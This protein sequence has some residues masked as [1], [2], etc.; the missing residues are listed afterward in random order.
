MTPAVAT[1]ETPQRAPLTALLISTRDPRGRMSGRKMV[2]RTIVA[3]LQGLGHRVVVAH[4]GPSEGPRR[5]GGVRYLPLPEAPG[6][7]RAMACVRALASGRR[8]V[9]EALYQS[10][11]ARSAIDTLVAVGDFDLVISDMA[12]TADYAA[13]TGLPWIADLDDLLSSRYR[14]MAHNDTSARN[15][16][17]YYRAPALQWL[18]RALGRLQPVFLEREAR[19]L[20]RREVEIAGQA[21]LVSLVSPTEAAELAGRTGRPVAATPMA[22]TGPSR[23]PPLQDRPH[24][25]VFLGGMDYGPNLNSVRQFDRMIRPALAARGLGEVALHVI[26]HAE[27]EHRRGLSE[28]VTFRGY[29]ADLDAA[30][31]GYRAMLV[32]EVAP[33][34]IKTKIVTAALNGSIVLCH[35]TALDGMGLAHGR[36][37]LA[38]SDA[39]ELADLIAGLRTGAIAVEP[40]AAAAHR[41]ATETFGE[42]RLRDLWAG[43]VAACLAAAGQRRPPA[44][45]GETAYG[46][47][48]QVRPVA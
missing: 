5:D 6:W 41:W 27:P 42:A 28:A 43:N 15:L 11:S 32:P 16:L 19:T 8:S 9:N 22:V 23:L 29:V 39:A 24:E 34:G 31:R 3:G 21:D 18:G 26:G 35:H 30:L 13:R 46:R 7:R 2:L 47:P 4:F 36:E 10:A 38:W 44:S 48:L 40:M 1:P 45:A 12:R 37:V 33:G 14:L 20:A 17:G 25:L